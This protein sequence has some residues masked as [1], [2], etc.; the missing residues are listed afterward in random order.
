MPGGFGTLDELFEIVTLI[1]T[2]LLK[3]VPIVLA[4]SSFWGNLYGWLEKELIS[5]EFITKKE[6]NFIKV[7]DDP[8]KIIKYITDFYS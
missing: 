7:F 1:S 3:P 6:L 8:E 4:D 5:K 2:C